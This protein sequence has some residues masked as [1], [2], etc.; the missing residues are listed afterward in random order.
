MD[1]DV[2]P[3]FQPP[4]KRRVKCNP[5]SEIQTKQ[6]QR[7]AEK[8][9]TRL[10]HNNFGKQD[11]A[12]HLTYRN[13]DEPTGEEEAQK[14]LRNFVKR[15]KRRYKKAGIELKYI[16]CTEYGKANGRVHHHLIL[17][18]GYDRD[19]IE[20]AWGHGYANSKRLQFGDDGITGLAHYIAKDKHFYKRWNQSRNL[21]IPEAAQFD[22]ALN[23][24]NIKEMQE[25]IESKGAH[26]YFE[27]LYPDFVLTDAA[28]SKN[29]INRG[30][31]I[32]FDMRRC[33]SLGRESGGSISPGATSGRRKTSDGQT[34]PGRGKTT[35]STKI[36]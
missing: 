3:V 10:T 9:L 12:V 4:G 18:G 15:L 29:S 35:K 14:H 16:S 23:A 27:E 20:K 2:Y 1:A 32:H 36:S 7:N 5:S 11:L 8:K 28:C 22:N 17:T 6:N 19:E 31:Y 21:D 33:E 25:A 24:D 30:L 13:E 34:P 26:K